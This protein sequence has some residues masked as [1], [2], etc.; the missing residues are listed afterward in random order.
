[1]TCPKCGFENQP[2]AVY[3]AKCATKLGTEASG[4]GIRGHVPNSREFGTCPRI[5]G[6]Y[7][8][9][10]PEI[11]G[12]GASE[13]G[14]ED[15]HAAQ[16]RA[17]FRNE[18]TRDDLLKDWAKES[19]S[20]GGSSSSRSWAPAGWGSSIAPTTRK[21]AKRSPSKSSIPISPSTRRRSTGSGTRSSWPAGSPTRTSAGCTS[22]T[23]TA[24]SCSSRWSMCR[25]R[26]SRG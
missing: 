13:G 1:M 10:R 20:P 18:N 11:R 25:G 24:R 7:P 26:T 17:N 3:C 5:L 19:C 12:W 6:R 2:G 21:S 9:P 14:V 16:S 22:S 15:R 4:T 23:R 8:A